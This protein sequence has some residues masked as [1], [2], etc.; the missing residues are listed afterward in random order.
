MLKQIFI[1]IG[2]L[3][4]ASGAGPC[5]MMAPDEMTDGGVCEQKTCANRLR[6]DVIRADN[7]TFLAGAY[8]FSLVAPDQ[9]GLH[10]SCYLNYVEEG[11]LCDEG[12]L[13]VMGAHLAADGKSMQMTV[14]AAPK[15]IAAT[16]TYSGWTIGEAE[17]VPTYKTLNPN[18]PDCPPTC[19]DGSTTMAVES[20]HKTH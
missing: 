19:L 15:A 2:L 10:V 7:E 3:L 20:W 12:D 5:D 4:I 16:V 1:L 9:S 11:L 17:L 14:Q 18:G 13:E 6:I 8:E